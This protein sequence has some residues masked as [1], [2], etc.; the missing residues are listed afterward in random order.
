[1]TE[2]IR[3][4]S[5]AFI[6]GLEKVVP[7]NHLKLLNYKEISKFLAGCAVISVEDMRTYARYEGCSE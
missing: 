2:N 6:E 4:Q 1:M 7:A 3:E 5:L